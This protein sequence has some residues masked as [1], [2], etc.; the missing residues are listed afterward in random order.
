MLDKLKEKLLN[1]FISGPCQFCRPHHSLI[2][3]SPNVEAEKSLQRQDYPLD[4]LLPEGFN[5]FAG[6]GVRPKIC[7]DGEVSHFNNCITIFGINNFFSLH[8][9]NNY[10][11]MAEL[12]VSDH[13]FQ[14][15]FL[16]LKIG[17][18][19]FIRR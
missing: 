10:H 9:K 5:P 12:L 11:K 18:S 14:S 7:V 4:T 16:V 3:L 15:N 1:V 17:D 2:S 6:Q 19:I 13:R 8:S